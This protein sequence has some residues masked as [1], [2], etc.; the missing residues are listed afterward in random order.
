VARD[1]RPTYRERVGELLDGAF[2]AREQLD[3]RPAVGVA[4]RVERVSG[5]AAER[6][7]CNGSRN[8]TV[9]R[10]KSYESSATIDGSPDA[11]WTIL[12]DA[13]AYAAW[14]SGVER[15]EGTI[16]PGETIK[17]RPTR[18]APSRSRSRSTTPAAP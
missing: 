9:A 13:P 5:N 3:D 14:D 6:D 8:V 17:D 18:A 7:S 11:I 4:E 16:A 10:M 15:V 2:A 1:R 12:T